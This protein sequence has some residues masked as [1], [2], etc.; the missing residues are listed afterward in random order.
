MD[1]PEAAQ[2]HTKKVYTGY[3]NTCALLITDMVICFGEPFKDQDELLS[4]DKIRSITLDSFF[5]CIV[6]SN[7]KAL[8]FIYNDIDESTIWSGYPRMVD[9]P[10][11]LRSKVDRVF[12]GT[13]AICVIKLNHKLYCWGIKINID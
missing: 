6:Y 11:V 4:K 12:S 10:E 2:R 9:I 7:G 5:M 1:I 3:S 13:L 8:C